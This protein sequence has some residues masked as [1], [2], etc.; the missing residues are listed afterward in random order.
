MRFTK[1]KRKITRERKNSHSGGLD[2]TKGKERRKEIVWLHHGV[3][4]RKR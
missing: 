1:Y 4:R 3:E 2:N